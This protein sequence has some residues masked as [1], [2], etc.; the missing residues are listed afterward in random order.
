[1]IAKKDLLN[2]RFMKYIFTLAL[3]SLGLSAA[4]KN[5]ID[6]L[7]VA[8]PAQFIDDYGSQHTISKTLWI[9]QPS[10]RYH[11][12]R[13]NLKEQYLVAR[14]DENNPS[15]KG[16]Y[17]RID[18]MRFSGMEPYTW[19]YCLT[20]YNAPSDSLAEHSQVK[21]DRQNPRKGCNGF[22]FTRMKKK[23]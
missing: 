9:Q 11:I 16:L 6:T 5:S 7:P 23:E 19:G 4:A 2:T 15:E 14:N 22:P 21:A 10:T 3:I 12:I 20:T 8:L 18:Y 17:T 1:M 13:W